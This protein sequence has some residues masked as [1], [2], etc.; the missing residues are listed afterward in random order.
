MLWRWRD[1]E[2]DVRRNSDAKPK[3]TK[4]AFRASFARNIRRML[5]MFMLKMASMSDLSTFQSIR[6]TLEFY[7]AAGGLESKLQASIECPQPQY[8]H[9]AP[10]TERD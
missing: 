4:N 8:M 10:S 3:Q 1:I 9:T 5:F 2:I 6:N 7:D